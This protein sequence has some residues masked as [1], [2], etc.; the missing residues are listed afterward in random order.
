MQRAEVLLEDLTDRDLIDIVV[1][2]EMVFTGYKFKDKEE[3]AP[4]LEKAG[5]GPTFTWCSNLAKRLG[6]WVF[7]G[8]PEKCIGEDGSE[9]FYNSQMVVNPAGEFVKSYK[10][11]FLYMTDK[12]WA[13]EG[14]GFETMDLKL[15]R[16]E[17][18]IKI[19]NGICMDINPWEFKS[20]FEKFEFSSFHKE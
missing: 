16:S 5:E 13:E 17:R 3:I 18:V 9:H 12:T 8:F 1:L 4:Y 10:K 15:P 2:S 19:G 11:H 6:C 20:E 7:C 14:P